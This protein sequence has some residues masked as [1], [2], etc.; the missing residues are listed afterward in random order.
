MSAFNVLKYD[1]IGVDISPS[2]IDKAKQNYPNYNFVVG[3]AL[4]GDTFERNTFT[5]IVCVYFT[6]YYLQNKKIFFENAMKWLMPGGY[7]VIHLV[8]RDKFDPILPPGNPLLF[9][10]PQKYAK[11][12]I[13]STNLVFDTFDYGANFDLNKDKNVAKFTERFKFKDGKTRKN[14]HVMYMESQDDILSEA[15]DVG[16][17]LDSQVDMV[18]CAYDYQYLY[19]LI[20]PS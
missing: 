14:E 12:R 10:S 13:T 8:N 16:F 18:Q 3:D 20:K 15:Q 1:V 17:I 7:L 2:M 5:H 6:I 9:V 11:K 4:K 19:V